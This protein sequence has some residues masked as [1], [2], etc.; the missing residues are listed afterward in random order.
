MP[1]LSQITTNSMAFSDTE[2]T[3]GLPGCDNNGCFRSNNPGSGSRSSTKR[4]FLET[5]DHHHHHLDHD[6]YDLDN[7]SSTTACSKSSS[8]VDDNNDYELQD[9]V[10]PARKATPSKAQVI[11]W[12]P[13]RSSRKK[14]MENGKYVKVAADGAAYLRKV[15]LEMYD[16]YE[17]LLKALD[18]MLAC[19]TNQGNYMEQSKAVK[20]M[21]YVPTYEDRDGDLMLVGDVPWKMF[22]ESCKRI[23]L[24]KSSEV[25]GLECT[26]T[27][28]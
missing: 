13:V 24:M 14:V 19:F 16:S 3:L 10:S 15:D 1:R 20:G 18:K 27:R 21:E 28:N 4:A 7:R 9:Q 26:S 22:I 25:V 23:R 6:H 8:K 17:Q 5:V 2:L 11:G 12:P